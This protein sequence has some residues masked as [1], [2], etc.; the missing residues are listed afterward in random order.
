MA[1]TGTTMKERAQAILKELSIWRRHLHQ[2]PE[3]SFSEYKTSD[4]IAGILEKIP[5]MQVERNAG[6]PTAVLGTLSSGDGPVVAMR[7]DMDAL[8]IQEE[9]V[10]DYRSREKGVMHAC[11]HDA[12]TAIV[13][14]AAHLLSTCFEEEKLKGTVKFIFQ[15]AE[16]RADDTGTTGAPYMLEHGVLDDV[17]AVFALH[18]DPEHPYGKIKLHDGFSMAN[19]DVFRARIKGT[20][21]H[22]AYP[23]LGSDPVWMLGN[24][25]Q[26]VY[27][28]TGRHVSSLESAVIS[29][30]SLE[31][32][33]A[34]NVIPAEVEIGG[35]IRTYKPEIRTKTHEELRRA[36]SIAESLGG[37]AELEI[38]AEDPALY[39]SP[40]VNREIE[41]AIHHLFP[42]FDVLDQPFGMGGEDFAHMARAI[43]G[44][45]FF[46]GCRPEA[47]RVRHLHTPIFD[48]DEQSLVAGTA[49]L[50]ETARQFVK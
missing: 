14:G 50:A 22:G 17:K 10:T 29:I 24:V 27:G 41:R 4:F 21:G 26:A 49:I 28:I 44:A 1:N 39:N 40:E 38:T 45:M 19:V 37:E 43:P 3:L 33:S 31:A 35:T 15:P 48:I 7:A 18:M 42:D 34:S 16:E 25:L 36:F 30:G 47:H 8:P 11:G 32:G 5:G 6:Y 23:H 12:H 9:N 20:G 2:F 46:L 13:L